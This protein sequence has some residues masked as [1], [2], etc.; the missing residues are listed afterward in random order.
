SKTVAMVA[1]MSHQKDHVTFLE[2]AQKIVARLPSTRFILVGDGPCRPMIE[3]KVKELGL[4][5]SVRILG[6]RHDAWEIV[7]HV[8]CCVLATHFEGCS[9]VIL[10]A[11]AAGKPVVATDVGGNRELIVDGETGFLIPPKNP[12]V[13][14]NMVLEILENPEKANMIGQRAQNRIAQNFTL[15]ET[16]RKTEALYLKLLQ[17]KGVF[18]P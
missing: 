4:T 17:E 5:G 1:R 11:M 8:D 15:H 16:V 13:L 18:T 3:S 12:M 9:N 10:E 14:A 7:Q 2:A 6:A